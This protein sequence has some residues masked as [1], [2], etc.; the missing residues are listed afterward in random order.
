MKKIIVSICLISSGF[1]SA[2][3]GWQKGGN[4]A[5]PPASPPTI[6]TN[7]NAPFIFLTNSIERGR[8]TTGGALNS[9]LGNVG[10][11]LRITAPAGT[12]GHL[13]LFT[14]NNAGANETHARFGN[15]GQV[16]G[17]NNRFEFISTGASVG[18]YYSTFA[19]G[20]IHR[21]DRGQTEYGR[22][23]TNNFGGSEKTTVVLFLAVST[24]VEGWR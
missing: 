7:W 18:N 19:A 17:Q 3:L 23:G 22:L 14:S 24:L 12:S 1:L 16:S 2:Q 8:F 20:G 13:D 11:G 15:S 10:D 4:N 21:F 6:G 9:W 5:T